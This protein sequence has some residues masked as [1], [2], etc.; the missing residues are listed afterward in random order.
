[1]TRAA[2]YRARAAKA[3]CTTEG[4]LALG[5]AVAALLVAC[6]AWFASASADD[7]SGAASAGSQGGYVLT[8]AVIS[9]CTG[10]SESQ[11]QINTSEALLEGL[12]FAV[13]NPFY[14]DV[15]EAL[16]SW[17][18]FPVRTDAWIEKCEFTYD[19][20]GRENTATFYKST[21]ELSRVQLSYDSHG[22]VSKAV[23]WTTLD[24]EGSS[25]RLDFEAAFVNEKLSEGVYG[26]NKAT[27]VHSGTLGNDTVVFTY[28]KD[29]NLT[30]IVST[31]GH[32]YKVQSSVNSTLKHVT[33][34]KIGEDGQ[35]SGTLFVPTYDGSNKLVSLATG[36]WEGDSVEMSGD[37]YEIQYS[38]GHYSKV[39]LYHDGQQV[40]YYEFKYDDN[41]NLSSI[42]VYKK[43]GIQL[44]NMT[45]SWEAK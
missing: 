19:E 30:D 10:S 1:M 12:S 9:D 3:L 13:G 26:A 2:A 27:V 37:E 33:Q 8:K 25:E 28:D 22:S 6:A 18:A 32:A 44:Y 38:K 40:K 5:L 23:G 14:V 31:G 42:R 41:G 35:D 17:Y 4:K 39:N 7:A 15:R 29:K 43:G 11:S 16:S 36:T 21:N 34:V 45:F 20:A 24:D